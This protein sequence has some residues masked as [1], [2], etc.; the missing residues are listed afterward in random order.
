[1]VWVF[2][3]AVGSSETPLGREEVLGNVRVELAD[4][5]FFENRAGIKCL[6]WFLIPLTLALLNSLPPLS[7][8]I[9]TC[10]ML[11]NQ[12][13]WL[14]LSE[15]YCRLTSMERKRRMRTYLKIFH[16]C[17]LLCGCGFGFASWAFFKVDDVTMQ[18]ILHAVVIGVACLAPQTM[19]FAPLATFCLS[20][21]SLLPISVFYFLKGDTTSLIAG[22]LFLGILAYLSYN[23]LRVYR[24]LKQAIQLKI[25]NADLANRMLQAKERAELGNRAK[26]DFLATMSHEIRTPMNGILGMLQILRETS[27][28]PRQHNYLNTA[29]D[30]AEALLE[31]LNDVL[32]F[33][34]IDAGHLE[35]EQISFDWIALIGEI[36]LLNR[37]LARQKGLDFHL[38]VPAEGIT[39]VTGD[40]SRLR[41]ILNNLISNALK[42]TEEGR[43]LVQAEIEE[44]TEETICLC[45]SVTDSGIGIDPDSCSKLFNVFTQ[46]DSSM[47]RR[48]GGSGLGL[49]ISQRLAKMMG[50]GID[51]SSVQGKG[52]C[53]TVRVRFP[54]APTDFLELPN[55]SI[56]AQL[57]KAHNFRG[58]V[59]LVEDDKVSQRVARIML[60]KYGIEPE[61]VSCGTDALKQ[62]QEAAWD[63]IF[64]DCQMP[65]MDGL[66]TTRRIRAQQPE[67]QWKPP[68]IVALTANVKKEDKEAC[69]AAG[70]N[71]FLMKPLRKEQ[72][73]QCLERYLSVTSKEAV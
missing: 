70:M 51:V 45:I 29:M 26:G 13:C 22:T 46:V 67:D 52:S 1:M 44:E 17:A 9:W 31:L 60:N 24:H 62:A 56:D 64:M 25:E 66:E 23:T 42:F 32:D 55:I 57:Q 19:S 40:P 34:K 72:L 3:I 39:Y 41:Q 68:V 7:V 61:I 14:G 15:H 35:L 21:A 69:F 59:L 33:S 20:F 10:V 12:L 11:A 37:I 54:K 8:S 71:D 73:R 2:M 27:L 30:S 16:V 18:I 49:S 4:L 6:F 38:D 36:A 63:L 48:Y 43:I 50:G 58:R 28:N 65:G 5:L 53:F 47:S